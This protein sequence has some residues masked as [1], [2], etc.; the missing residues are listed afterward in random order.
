MPKKMDHTQPKMSGPSKNWK[1]PSTKVPHEQLPLPSISLT[2]CVHALADIIVPHPGSTIL[3]TRHTICHG[4]RRVKTSEPPHMASSPS[5]EELRQV[6]T[7][8]ELSEF[9]L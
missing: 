4:A 1:K 8:V 6:Y 2:A 9:S 7:S 3:S 5:F